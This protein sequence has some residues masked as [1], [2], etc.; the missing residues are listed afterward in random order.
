MVGNSHNNAL[1]SILSRH[2]LRPNPYAAQ[3]LEGQR[4]EHIEVTPRSDKALNLG[5]SIFATLTQYP[6]S[7]PQHIQTLLDALHVLTLARHPND[8][9]EEDWQLTLKTAQ[10]LRAN[11]HKSVS[12][13]LKILG[14]KGE[15]SLQTFVSTCLISHES[16]ETMEQSFTGWS[17]IR[18]ELTSNIY[19]WPTSL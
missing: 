12:K 5:T 17:A 18:D 7:C 16:P 14:A 1:Y 11:L 4:Q 3:N 19:G 9:H 15:E 13:D 2:V 8:K 10:I 6:H